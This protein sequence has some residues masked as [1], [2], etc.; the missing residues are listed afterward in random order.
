MNKS[1]NTQAWI[2]QFPEGQT[3]QNILNL[4]AIRGLA[5]IEQCQSLQNELNAKQLRSLLAAWSQDQADRTPLLRTLRISYERQTGNLRLVY[6]LTETGASLLN[7]IT[8]QDNVVASK[9]EDKVECVHAVAEMDVFTRARAASLDCILEKP[10]YFG[11]KKENIRAD[12]ALV[13]GENAFRLIEIEQAAEPKQ[14]PRIT[15]KLLHLMNFFRSA[16]A[17]QVENKILMLFNLASDDQET[18]PLWRKVVTALE[19]QHGP[20]PFQLLTANLIDFL[21]RPVWQD[22][23]QYLAIQAE[24]VVTQVSVQP[25]AFVAPLA[26]PITENKPEPVDL[27]PPFL[28]HRPAEASCFDIIL[29]VLKKDLLQT[30]TESAEDNQ[31][32]FFNLALIIYA[33]S[34]Y[35]DSPVV[36]KSAFPS[37]SLAL[38][39]RYLH[40]HQNEVLLVS[41]KREIR[42]LQRANIRGASLFR[43]TFNQLAWTLLRHYGFGRGGPLQVQV[44]VPSFSDERS[45]IHLE[46]RWEA[47]TSMQQTYGL[48]LFDLEKPAQKGEYLPYW[49]SPVST[50]NNWQVLTAVAW[51]LNALWVYMED[52]GLKPEETRKKK[53]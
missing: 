38:L 48:S 49:Q 29:D 16:D 6:L 41:L 3:N 43:D 53:A 33:G 20:L 9:I 15:D 44:K 31:R 25:A 45:D 1:P 39:Y 37:I 32:I 19:K 42:E 47:E 7:K 22:W 34:H 28:K 46:L 51:L 18:L 24:Q 4:F 35:P 17:R 2:N 11:P 14:V 5:T 13:K 10:F 30:V 27:T 8:H 36:T 26:E 40:A 23:D 50:K 21:E 52:L 12:I